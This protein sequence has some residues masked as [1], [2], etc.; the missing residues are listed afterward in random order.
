MQHYQ[1]A[2]HQNRFHFPRGLLTYRH[3]L[4]FKG[5]YDLLRLRWRRALHQSR[6][7]PEFFFNF[8][9]KYRKNTRDE[10]KLFVSLHKIIDLARKTG[11][12]DFPTP[13]KWHKDEKQREGDSQKEDPW[14]QWVQWRPKPQRNKDD[15][16]SKGKEDEQTTDNSKDKDKDKDKDN[17]NDPFGF[18][19]DDGLKTFQRFLIIGALALFVLY[20]ISKE[21]VPESTI[22]RFENDVINHQVSRIEVVNKNKVRVYYRHEPRVPAYY[23]NIG[24]LDAFEAQLEA[25]RANSNLKSQPILIRYTEE[26]NLFKFALEWLPGFLIVTALFYFFWSVSKMMNA[27]GGRNIFSFGKANAKMWHK[28]EKVKVTFKDVAGCDEAKI[29]IQEFVHFL[30]NPKK[31]KELGAR[32]PKGALL[33]GPPGTGK[34]LLAKATAGEA[35]VPFFSISGSDFIELFVGVGPA[36]VRDLFRLGRQ[37]APCII[38]IDEIDAIGRARGRGAF[39]GVHDERE[40]TLNAL[41]V[42]M[43]GFSTQDGIVVFAG[44]NRPDVLDKALMRPGRFDRTIY[45]DHPDLKAR[46][47]IFLVHMK[48]L[49]LAQPAT[50]Y[51]KRLAA[52]TPGFTGADIANVCNEA[53][54]IAARHDKQAITMQDF[55]KA[56]DRVIGGLEK[57]TRILS[58]EE[59]KI[60]AYHESGHAIVGWFLEYTDPVLKVSI[61]PRGGNALG[62]SQQLPEERHLMTR[63]QLLDMICMALGGRAAEEIKFGS[64]TTGA[65]DDLQ[66]VT[67]MA[68]AQMLAWGMSDKVGYVSFTSRRRNEN[69]LGKPYSDY[70]AQIVDEEVRNLVNEAYQRTIKLL[71]EKFDLLEKLA[72]RLLDKEVVTHDEIKEILGPR[73]YTRPEQ[74][75]WL[76]FTEPT[77]DSKSTTTATATA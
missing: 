6:S 60:V 54:L 34:T 71:Q 9:T 65:V 14:E 5:P 18:D 43:D 29:E 28:G 67:Q 77:T 7:E 26:I 45:I 62:F 12:E 38:F 58:P 15:D 61:I 48:G 49:K 63:E 22:T 69:Y 51:V 47:E 72:A 56:I 4:I 1:I 30:K 39:Q 53:A 42:E 55:D 2:L 52:L 25:L 41:L 33:V 27:R 3:N 70:T 76:K 44:T 20:L 11:W 68:Y 13:E 57:K 36:R 21:R 50:T 59:K 73:P 66:R 19:I 64:I 10:N 24:S 75:Q 40:S 74:E 8:P 32:I 46:E 17:D 35:N 23:F 31:Y 37:N 16:R